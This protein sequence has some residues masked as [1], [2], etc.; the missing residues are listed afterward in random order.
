MNRY[1]I[2]ADDYATFSGTLQVWCTTCPTT[3]P[4]THGRRLL[5]SDRPHTLDELIELTTNHT[6]EVHQ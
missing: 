4:M 2:L 3:T 5:A 1:L 6:I